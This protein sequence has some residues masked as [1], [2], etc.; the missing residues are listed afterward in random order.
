MIARFVCLLPIPLRLKLV[1]NKHFHT[2]Q[3]SLTIKGFSSFVFSPE[4][5]YIAALHNVHFVK[6]DGPVVKS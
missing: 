5:E 2:Y 6:Y 1:G 3:M 4:S